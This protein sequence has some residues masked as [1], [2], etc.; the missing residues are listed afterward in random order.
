MKVII[1]SLK[2]R[3]MRKTDGKTKIDKIKNEM[4]RNSL[5]VEPDSVIIGKV[6]VQIQY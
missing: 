6:V 5:N 4:F 2:M 3:K 1:N